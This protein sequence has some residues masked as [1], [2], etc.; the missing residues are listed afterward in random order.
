[1]SGK[2]ASLS[3]ALHRLM[4]FYNP[5]W[6]RWSF[7]G[8][9]VWSPWDCGELFNDRER[10]SGL[11]RWCIDTQTQRKL[12]RI[13]AATSTHI[14]GWWKC[15]IECLSQDV[16]SFHHYS[17]SIRSNR[18][19]EKTPLIQLKLVNSCCSCRRFRRQALCPFCPSVDFSFMEI[20]FESC[21]PLVPFWMT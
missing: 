7:S 15:C 4:H 19:A 16:L 10:R 9:D 8:L 2:E 5:W 13:E 11:F 1:M 3:D 14:I 18:I 6:S 20:V 17:P 12:F 21:T